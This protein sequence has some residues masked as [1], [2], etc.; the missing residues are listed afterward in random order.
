MVKV[1]ERTTRAGSG[2]R[3]NPAIL[4]SKKTAN[5]TAEQRWQ[6]IAEAAYYRVLRRGFQ[7]GDPARDWQEA[8]IEVDRRLQGSPSQ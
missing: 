8:E 7:G 4:A 1:I 5:T 2:K 6:M 3:A